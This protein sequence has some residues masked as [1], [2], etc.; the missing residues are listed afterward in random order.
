MGGLKI[1]RLRRPLQNVE[2]EVLFHIMVA[3]MEYP[4]SEVRQ[5]LK[6]I[7]QELGPEK[8]LWGSD[9]PCVERNCTYRQS[10][11]WLSKHCNF[12]ESED[13]KLILG[14]NAAELFNV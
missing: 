14:G 9:M 3:D 11:D 7:Y 12:I 6:E 1:W 8:L 5:P 2:L 4:Y 13:M 10:L